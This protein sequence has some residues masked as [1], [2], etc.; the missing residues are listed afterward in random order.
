MNRLKQKRSKQKGVVAIETALG[1]FA[2]LLMIFFWME[3]SYM[4]FVSALMDYSVSESARVAKASGDDR[5][6]NSVFED[7]VRKGGNSS[8]WGQFLD[9]SKIS[10]RISYYNKVS[11]VKNPACLIGEPEEGSLEVCSTTEDEDKP[12]PIAIYQVTYPY[13]PLLLSLFFDTDTLSIKREVI[14]IQEYERS[15]FY[16]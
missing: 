7:E 11:D 16:D 6:Y 8:L 3:V 2:F 9:V 14:T 12:N 5:N 4:G 15:K 1:L 13:A 10:I